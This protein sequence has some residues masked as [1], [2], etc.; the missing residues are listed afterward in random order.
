MLFEFI[1]FTLGAR[2]LSVFLYLKKENGL[3][4][5]QVCPSTEYKLCN[6]TSSNTNEYPFN[7]NPPV[8]S[9]LNKVSV[10]LFQ[11]GKKRCPF[12]AGTR[13]RTIVSSARVCRQFSAIGFQFPEDFMCVRAQ[14]IKWQF[15]FS[16]SF[17]CRT[18]LFKLGFELWMCF[19]GLRNSAEINQE[20]GLILRYSMFI[21]ALVS[22][23]I[24]ALVSMFMCALRR[25]AEKF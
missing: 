13:N 14:H 10:I 21:Y 11:S 20:T 15:A 7:L 16:L 18:L 24:R 6:G 22:M 19:A 5:F 12:N 8:I 23:F 1:L 25:K 3:W 17:I 4:V 2:T 9:Q